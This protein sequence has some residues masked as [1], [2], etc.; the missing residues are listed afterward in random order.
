V[1]AR[2][3]V[4]ALSL[5]LLAAGCS[6]CPDPF[7]ELTT[8]DPVVRLPTDEAPHCFGGV[9]WW[10]YSGRLTAGAD[11]EFGIEI[12]IF[13]VPP[14]PLLL[15]G[16][17]WVAHFA[18]IDVHSAQFKY[19]QVEVRGP[20]S[21]TL[22]GNGFDLHTPLVHMRGG[23]GLDFV[24]AT[25]ADR[26]YSV[27]LELLDQR[28]PVLH[29]GDGY[30]PFGANGQAFYYSRPHM[31]AS[32]TFSIGDEQFTVSGRVW[33][34]RQWGRDIN[35]PHQHWQWFSL[36]MNDGTDIMFYQFPRRNAAVAFGTL[37]PPSG[38]SVSLSA[39][40]FRVAP[41]ATWL[42]PATGIEYAVGWTIELPRDGTVLTLAAVVDDVELETR[43]TTR[44][45]YWEGLC[46]VRSSS[47]PDRVD[48]Y[49]YVE[50][51]NGS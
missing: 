2:H 37:I 31:D 10:Y 16:E 29:E 48:G 22:P 32:G 11:R 23:D 4:L 40:D 24:Q 3:Y 17:R 8:P 7:Y 44:E 1:L 36:R 38:P 21:A 46:T 39:E 47:H 9:E 43:A 50:Q 14:L 35:N 12:V 42:S 25:F 45:V 6:C 26:S 41:T 19:D 49:A 15:G 34:D 30:V 20:Q 5:P 51:V 27:S 18:V 28:G 13:H 33:F